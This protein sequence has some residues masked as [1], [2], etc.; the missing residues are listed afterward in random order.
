MFAA[1]LIL[2]ILIIAS[3]LAMFVDANVTIGVEAVTAAVAVVIVARKQ[4][5]ADAK[6]LVDLSRPVLVLAALPALWMIIQILPLGYLG[7]Q[8]PGGQPR[9]RPLAIP[10]QAALRSTPG[11]PFSA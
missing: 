1:F 5:A 6:S 3:P 7:I 2:I 11:P 10:S 8:N 4:R 9:N